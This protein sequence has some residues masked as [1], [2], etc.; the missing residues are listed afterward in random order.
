MIEHRRA[1]RLVGELADLVVVD[2]PGR[3]GRAVG[4]DCAASVEPVPIAYSCDHRVRDLGHPLEVVGGAGRDRAEH[5]LLGG[6]AAEQHR[7]EV[8]QLLAG[9]QVAVLL[10]EVERVAERLPAGHDRDPVHAVDRGQQLAAQ[11]VAGLV[12][13]D[14]ALLVVGQRAARL[15]PRHHP[16]ERGVEVD[17]SR[18]APRRGGR[19]RSPP[20]CRCSRGRRRS[21]PRSGAR[22]A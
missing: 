16:L 12:V 11:R 18:P 5:E 6:P 17:A 19:R 8:D 20:R 21:G 9:L 1:E 2:A 7:H 15:H 14:D 4:D 13:G 3:L 22:A 10:G